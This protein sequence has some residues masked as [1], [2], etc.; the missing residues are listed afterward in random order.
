MK[1]YSEPEDSA[2]CSKFKEKSFLSAAELTVRVSLNEENCPIC[3]Q[4]KLNSGTLKGD[5]YSWRLNFSV[6]LVVTFF[7][8]GALFAQQ[9]TQQISLTT[10]VVDSVPQTT[11]VPV[12]QRSNSLVEHTTIYE[13]PAKKMTRPE[14][15]AL[16]AQIYAAKIDSLIGSRN[17]IFFPNS[18]QLIPGGMIRSVLADYFIFGLFVDHAE[19]HLPWGLGYAETPETLNFDSMSV[20]NYEARQKQG[21]WNIS[22]DVTD[23]VTVYHAELSVST[24]TG[25]TI[26]TLMTPELEMR[27]VGWLWNRRDD[28]PK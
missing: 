12:Q 22:F 21:G 20:E 17:Y 7:S 23:G 18:M 10:S 27:Y 1:I 25:E 28:A 14:R 26:L 4:R 16:R 3:R 5:L 6:G 11:I 15:R 9:P 2:A 8:V 24:V 13:D 19:I